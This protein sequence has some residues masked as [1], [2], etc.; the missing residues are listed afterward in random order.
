M[1]RYAI[2]IFEL[3]LCPKPQDI[4]RRDFKLDNYL[5]MC[6][7]CIVISLIGG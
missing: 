4:F 6:D 2:T 3:G 1:N 7:T 5:N